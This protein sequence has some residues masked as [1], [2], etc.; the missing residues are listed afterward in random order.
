MKLN[1]IVKELEKVAPFSLS[2]EYCEKF[3]H[4]DNSGII[5]NCGNEINGILFSLDFS[6]TAINTALNGG[7]NLIVTH[8]PAIFGAI[9]NLNAE[10]SI[11]SKKLMLCIKNGISVVSAHLNLDA[12]KNGVDYYLMKGMGG[13]YA[14][15]MDELSCG[16]YGRVYQIPEIQ[17]SEL[18]K[19]TAKEFQT[20][21]SRFYGDD[22][23]VITVA[24]FCG[25][26]TDEKSIEFAYKNGADVFVSSD[27]KHHFITEL[28]ERGICVIELT[29]YSSENYGFTQIAKNIMNELTIPCGIYADKNLL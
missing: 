6:F 8:H 3:G 29:H 12:A 7:Y 13:I 10:E 24:S 20:E 25:S 23:K 15:I 16:G 14:K 9:K 19:K 4:Y 22:K 2:S 17:F 11:L 27:I 28:Y 21:K 26:G 18:C 1:E 5:I